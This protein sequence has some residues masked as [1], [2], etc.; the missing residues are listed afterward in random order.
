MMR[1]NGGRPNRSSKEAM[2]TQWSEGFG[3]FAQSVQ[4]AYQTTHKVGTMGKGTLRKCE[5]KMAEE[6]VQ[7][8][9][10]SF[11]SLAIGSSV[12]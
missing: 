7:E 10:K 12:M 8:Q 5:C 6:K 4:P 11:S 3:L 9:S 1:D 2:E